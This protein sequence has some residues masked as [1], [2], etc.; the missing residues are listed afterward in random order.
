VDYSKAKYYG[1][2]YQH[3]AAEWGGI[4]HIERLAILEEGL[5]GIKGTF[6]GLKELSIPKKLKTQDYIDFALKVHQLHAYLISD[7]VLEAFCTTADSQFAIWKKFD[8]GMEKATT[9]SD[10]PPIENLNINELPGK[11]TTTGEKKPQSTRPQRLQKGPPPNYVPAPDTPGA[12]RVL[13]QKET[14]AKDRK[15][16]KADAANIKAGNGDILQGPRTVA[17]RQTNFANVWKDLHKENLKTIGTNMKAFM[18][19]ISEAIEKAPDYKKVIEDPAVRANVE[20]IKNFEVTFP[21]MVSK[22][23]KTLT[24]PTI[25][26]TQYPAAPVAKADARP[27]TPEARPSS[28]RFQDP[29]TPGGGPSGSTPQDTP[30]GPNKLKKLPPA[31][32]KQQKL[33]QKQQKEAELAQKQ[34]K[35]PKGSKRD[36]LSKRGWVWRIGAMMVG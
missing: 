2:V 34:Q 25:L 36:W 28:S 7:T 15:Y 27:N 30:S 8:S 1:S 19:S 11:Q 22:K 26:G 3:S 31:L 13:P 5:N 21:D 6:F 23:S 17:P 35:K 4:E 14:P 33:E 12:I 29:Q 20:K 16:S 9:E 10:L 18:K 24:E 32:K